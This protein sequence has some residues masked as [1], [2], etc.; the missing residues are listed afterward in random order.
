MMALATISLD[1]CGR[2]VHC[3]PL[4]VVTYRW[5]P[6]RQRGWCFTATRERVCQT[7][8]RPEVWLRGTPFLARAVVRHRHAHIAITT[9]TLPSMAHTFSASAHKIR[10]INARSLTGFTFLSHY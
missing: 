3:D 9:P 6:S 7:T 8:I 4:A 5:V 2:R 10:S 1:R